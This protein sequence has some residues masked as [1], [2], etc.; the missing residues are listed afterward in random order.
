MYSKIYTHYLTV[1]IILQG[2][3]MRKLLILFLFCSILLSSFSN[4]MAIDKISP[5]TNVKIFYKDKQWNF[6]STPVKYNNKVMVPGYEVM[7]NLDIE[8]TSSFYKGYSDNI[9]NFIWSVLTDDKAILIQVGKSNVWVNGDSVELDVAPIVYNRI[10]YV[11]LSF[12]SDV[13]C[14]S[15]SY[16]NTISRVIISDISQPEPK[17]WTKLKDRAKGNEQETIVMQG[18]T[19][20]IGSISFYTNDQNKAVA[21]GDNIYMIDNDGTLVE[22]NPSSDIWTNKF[23]IQELNNTNGNFSLGVLDGKILIIGVNYNT[24]Y[25]YDIHSNSCKLLTTIPIEIAAC[26][27]LVAEGKIYILSGMEVGDINTLTTLYVYDPIAD[28]WTKKKDMFQGANNLTSVY[29]NGQIYIFGSV[30]STYTNI[31]DMLEIDP[32]T[33]NMRFKNMNDEDRYPGQNIEVYDIKTDTWS[34]VTPYDAQYFVSG[35]GVYDN[36]LLV[37]GKSSDECSVIEYNPNNNSWSKISDML[38]QNGGYST[39]TINKDIF[40]INGTSVKKF[41]PNEVKLSKNKLN[42]QDILA[43][44][45]MDKSQIESQLGTDYIMSY[46]GTDKGLTAVKYKKY[47]ITIYYMMN[48]YID[49]IECGNTI[50]IQNLHIGMNYNQIKKIISNANI[51][52][53]GQLQGNKNGKYNI[54]CLKD[55]LL[56]KFGILNEKGASISMTVRERNRTYIKKLKPI[57]ED[58]LQVAKYKLHML[59]DDFEKIMPSGLKDKEISFDTAHNITQITYKYSDGSEFVFKD[60]ELCSIL[61]ANSKYL[62]P[63]GLKVGDSI[64]RLVILYG[65]PKARVLESWDY[66]Y[67]YDERVFTIIE[68]DG[69]VNGIKI[70]LAF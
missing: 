35:A 67:P 48:G 34:Y 33:G 54:E 14:K 62:T 22:Y 29:Y 66:M 30:K 36:K 19:P 38:P 8:V 32:E 68:K 25:E 65:N 39:V 53:V 60:D 23:K 13:L 4:V 20:G 59:R 63:R 45:K 42:E 11:P 52:K 6:Y 21:L 40:F 1:S 64:T 44:L 16:D 69:K 55:N 24:I 57:G 12:I 43:L 47:D 58:D 7:K 3:N 28:I 31:E 2:G 37:F 50:D 26:S 61:S 9:N 46:I 51:K 70:A 18:T 27:V 15:I 10:M 56:I 49:Y 17:G 41:T 5:D